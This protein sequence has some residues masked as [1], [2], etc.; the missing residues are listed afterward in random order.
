MR[1]I[2]MKAWDGLDEKEISL[3]AIKGYVEMNEDR[4]MTL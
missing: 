2:L 1:R 4:E 3:Y